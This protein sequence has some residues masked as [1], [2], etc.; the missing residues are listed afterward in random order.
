MAKVTKA[1]STLQLGGSSL[2]GDPETAAPAEQGSTP[3]S[4]TQNTAERPRLR[5]LLQTPRCAS[6]EIQGGGTSD[7]E[8]RPRCSRH[9]GQAKFLRILPLSLA[10]PQWEDTRRE[11]R[12]S[13]GASRVRGRRQLGACKSTTA[14]GGTR[15]ARSLTTPQLFISAQVRMSRFMRLSLQWP[16]C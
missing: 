15:G 3:L 13:A 10:F 4:P 8:R 1:A 2:W 7:E 12:A 11:R 5:A 6:R 16:L 9:G 14:A